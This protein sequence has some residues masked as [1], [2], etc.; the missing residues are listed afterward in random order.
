MSKSTPIAKITPKSVPA[1]EAKGAVEAQSAVDVKGVQLAGKAPEKKESTSVENPRHIVRQGVVII[2]LFFGLLG[3]WAIF[4]ELSGAVVAPGK[5]KI[6]TERKTVQHLEGGIVDSILVS[7]GEIVKEGQT[8]ITLESVQ[9]DA[10]EAQLRQQV[11]TLA[12]QEARFTAERDLADQVSM[13]EVLT[14]NMDAPYVRT[15]VENE[16]KIF[17]ARKEA[18]EGQIS[19]LKFQI[20]QLGAQIVGFNEQ[21]K[22]EAAIIGTL[23]EELTAK[24]QLFKERYVEKSQILQLER[25]LASHQGN[26]GRLRQA[27]AETQQRESELKLR[28]EDTKNRFIEDATNNIGKVHN[29]LLQARE[30][31]RPLKDAK[32]RLNVVAPVSGRVVGLKVHSTGGVVRSGEPLMDIVPD[33]NPLIVEMQVPVNKITDVYIGQE[34]QVQ[35]DAFDIRVTPLIKAKVIYISA[36]RLEERTQYGEM[37]Y[38]LCYVEIDPADMKANNVYLSPGMPATVFITTKKQT[39][40]YYMME[41]LVKNWQRAL[42]E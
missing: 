18:L 29:D 5:V 39:I 41:P 10:S 37:P 40:M 22:A 42:R 23:Q 12:A 35:L 31:L 30:R 32:K 2:L 21:I 4:G 26:K 13:P 36:D 19:L 25:E 9:I 1:S 16:L 17:K 38:Y 24:R 3:A 6:E 15:A 34:A 20:A 8:L 7:E 28:I 11:A 33:D 27:V 14:N